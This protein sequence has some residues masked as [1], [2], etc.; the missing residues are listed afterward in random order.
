MSGLLMGILGYISVVYY[1]AHNPEYRSM[2]LFLA[3]NVLLGFG[4]GIS[5]IGHLSGAIIGVL[6]GIIGPRAARSNS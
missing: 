6:L 1:R 3:I 4:S 5:F 2:L